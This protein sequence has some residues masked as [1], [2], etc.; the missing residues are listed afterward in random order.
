ML[1]GVGPHI[2]IEYLHLGKSALQVR[3][4]QYSYKI[5]LYFRFVAQCRDLRVFSYPSEGQLG[6]SH[7]SLKP[8]ILQ[9]CW[10]AAI[11][12]LHTGC[13]SVVLIGVDVKQG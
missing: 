10:A 1:G 11:K 2:H 12:N 3:I 6:A 7:L 13:L 4:A 9:V 5:Y 8:L